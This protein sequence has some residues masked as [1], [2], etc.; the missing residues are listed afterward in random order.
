MK[1]KEEFLN[2]IID[3]LPMA[4]Y[5]S[6]M[7]KDEWKGW[8]EDAY[9]EGYKQAKALQL[10]QTGVIRSSEYENIKG[11]MEDRI[12][13]WWNEKL[14]EY[15]RRLLVRKHF[16]GGNSENIDTISGLMFEEIKE[17]YCE[18]FNIVM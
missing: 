5:R 13:T 3:D 8:F 12:K 6:Q 9:N 4:E 17:I 15:Q 10:Q 14:T 2:K 16:K 11:T 1:N 18:R 7:T